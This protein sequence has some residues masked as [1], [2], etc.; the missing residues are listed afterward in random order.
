MKTA[1][2]E[3]RITA[4]ESS[5]QGIERAPST[6]GLATENISFDYAALAP[7]EAAELRSQAVRLRGLI[8]RTT[9]DMIEVGVGLLA[10]SW[11]MG[12]S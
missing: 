10:I 12:S 5:V 8:T 2:S 6:S 7:T 1:R 3:I 9:A 11:N 4:L